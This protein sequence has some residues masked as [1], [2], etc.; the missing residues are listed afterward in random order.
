M[1][2]VPELVDR[3]YTSVKKVVMSHGCKPLTMDMT[4]FSMHGIFLD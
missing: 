3:F 4:I 2:G 1:V